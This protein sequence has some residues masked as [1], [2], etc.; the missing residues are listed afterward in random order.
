MQ[1]RNMTLAQIAAVAGYTPESDGRLPLSCCQ[2][3]SDAL[4]KGA[5]LLL[6]AWRGGDEVLS[7]TLIG[8]G[9]T[10]A[11]L[12]IT[13]ALQVHCAQVKYSEPG[14]PTIVI[15]DRDHLQALRATRVYRFFVLQVL[16]T[17]DMYGPFTT[18]EEARNRMSQLGG[19][20]YDVVELKS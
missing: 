8:P 16:K 4:A 6:Q 10:W 15:W 14:A 18:A 5:V 1:T 7:V 20:G 17:N 9:P 3:D 12:A 19:G 11:Y 2:A 13:N